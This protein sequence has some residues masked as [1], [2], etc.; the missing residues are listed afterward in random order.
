MIDLFFFYKNIG[1]FILYLKYSNKNFHYTDILEFSKLVIF[2]DIININDLNNVN[3]L[4]NIFF[5][6][7]YFG[8]LP[9][10]TN[11][12]YK[13]KLNIHYFSFFIQYNFFNENIYFP[14]FYFLNDVYFMINKSN[15]A[16]DKNLNY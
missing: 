6:R 11:Y 10:F 5:F 4:S 12:N 9:F 14:I 1:R 15:I 16:V 8:I 3:I 13:F 2:F 7:Y